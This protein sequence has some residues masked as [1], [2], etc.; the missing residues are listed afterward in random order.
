M[1]ACFVLVVKEPAR[2]GKSLCLHGPA[3]WGR[4]G[5]GSLKDAHHLQQV[6]SLCPGN[7]NCSVWQPQ[8]MDELS[9][10]ES[11]PEGVLA[12]GACGDRACVRAGTGPHPQ[13]ALLI[14]LTGCWGRLLG[15]KMGNTS[16]NQFDD[17]VHLKCD[18]N[19]PH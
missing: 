1:K 15:G 17:S 7:K 2:L 3:L 18:P 5:R 11:V 12:G 14:R 4:Y 10:A 8:L 13:R 9:G 6:A 19:P 16:E